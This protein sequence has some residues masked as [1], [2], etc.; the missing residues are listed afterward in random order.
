MSSASEDPRFTVDTHLFRELGELLVGRDST[1]LIE[2]IKNSYDADATEVI[3]QGESLDDPRRG[4]IVVMDNGV[5]MTRGQFISGF[6]RVA[7][8][9]KELGTRR[10]TRFGR[11][12]TGVKGIGRLA[13][14]K[15]A[16]RLE[17][18][19]VTSGTSP[20]ALHAVIDWDKIEGYETLDDIPP[21]TISFGER[22]A[23]PD[24]LSGTTLT[25]SRLRRKWTQAERSRFLA[26]V[27]SFQ[28]PDFIQDPLPKTVIPAPLL[29]D[30][31]EVRD[32]GAA[33]GS[34]PAVGFRVVLDGD[35]ETGDD[36]WELVADLATWVVEMQAAPGS[37][38]V[39]Y[40]I[41]P[42]RRT[43]EENPDARGYSDSVRRASS[44]PCFDARI[45][46]REGHFRVRRDQRVWAS[47]ASGVHVFLEGFRVLPYGDDDWLSIDS[48][49]TRRPRQLELLRDLD[50][51]AEWDDTDVDEGLTRLPKNNY[52]GGVFL[53]QEHAPTLRILVNREG[54]VPE[55]GFLALVEHVRT[56]VDLC[57]RVRAAAGLAER[58]KR[59]ALRAAAREAKLSTTATRSLRAEIKDAEGVIKEIHAFLG[60]RDLEGAESLVER[61]VVTLEHVRD[62]A[63]AIIWEGS[64]LRILASVGTQM[65][66]FVH[67]VNGLL[68]TA[69]T[70]DQSIKVILEE[71]A[72]IGEER[73]RLQ[74]AWRVA[75][76]LR[77]AVERHASYLTGVVSVNARRRRSRQLIA[78][79][80]DSAVRLVQHSADRHHVEILAD[81][82]P[83]LRSPPMFPAELATIFANL[84]TNAVKAAGPDGRIHASAA[85]DSNGLRV[86]VQ[87]TGVAVDLGQ[88]ERWFRPFE[89]TTDNPD[90]TLGQGMGLGLT[91]TRSMLEYYGLSV[92]FVEPSTPYATAV[93]VKF[94]K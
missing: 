15:L 46:I 51:S 62:R 29:F 64:M 80:F 16:R 33:A 84:L 6:L 69:Q 34:T 25:L 59:A 28:A 44:S 87:N 57:T 79:R 75:V 55:A 36:Y 73:R 71:G 74:G 14:H 53:T 41:A 18:E 82:P 72:L 42:T 1:A 32:I 81:I 48:D 3:V 90:S 17:V 2:L 24:A 63:D 58:R 10:S 54:F 23:R 11:R 30:L 88:A 83:T 27:S 47:R 4:R 8:R 50:F 5:G 20:T 7:S 91:I 61:A 22:A 60:Q 43:L 26:E 52:F 19:S 70:L 31:P 56:G 77:Q 66:A 92:R 85:S 49:Y 76:D 13:A 89:S 94:S 38:K 35:F 68:G 65:A 40:A 78:E 86:R 39:V 37:E 67:E 9:F 45:L 21:G 12:Y 93:E